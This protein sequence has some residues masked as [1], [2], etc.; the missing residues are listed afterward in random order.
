MLKILAPL[1]LVALIGCEASHTET[2]KN[3]PP[4][5][6][7]PATNNAP[8]NPPGPSTPPA[9]PTTGTAPSTGVPA[10]TANAA[11]PKAEA[12]NIFAQRCSVCHGMN[13][14]GDGVGA[15]ALNPKPRNYTDVAWQASVTDDQIAKT[16]VEGGAAVG[17]SPLMAPNADLK[18]KPEVVKALVAKVRSFKGQ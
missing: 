8:T 16:I 4:G 9:P 10:T 7:S 6:P 15:A 17:K 11:D 2:D 5:A 18:D 1:A 3:P 14:K 13:G 12:D